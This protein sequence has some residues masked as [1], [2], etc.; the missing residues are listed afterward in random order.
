[1]K[2]FSPL[3]LGDI[4]NSENSVGSTTL[5]L[6][7]PFKVATDSESQKLLFFFRLLLRP[8]WFES[9]SRFLFLNRHFCA[10]KDPFVMLLLNISNDYLL[11]IMAKS[12]I[13]SFAKDTDRF[14]PP[15]SKHWGKIWKWSSKLSFCFIRPT[16]TNNNRVLPISYV[17]SNPFTK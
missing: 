5:D 4:L 15:S 11:L 7:D 16:W 2:V 17:V 10:C 12:S 8:R 13:R 1:M 14:A 6:D 3:G 9:F